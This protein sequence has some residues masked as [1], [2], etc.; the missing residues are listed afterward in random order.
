MKI[1]HC[2]KCE[3]E[4]RQIYSYPQVKIT[5]LLR[6]SASDVY[7]DAV[8]LLP[9]AAVELFNRYLKDIPAE[10]RTYGVLISQLMVASTLRDYLEFLSNITGKETRT[11]QITNPKQLPKGLELAFIDSEFTEKNPRVLKGKNGVIR[12]ER[13]E[14]GT[15]LLAGIDPRKFDGSPLVDVAY[16]S[17]RGILNP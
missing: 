8:K 2:P 1:L 17:Y 11:N 9:K 14:Q 10:Q 5:N 4:L 6:R 16:L 12:L 3:Q 15:T 13:G 7:S